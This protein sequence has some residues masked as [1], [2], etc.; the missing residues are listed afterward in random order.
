MVISRANTKKVCFSLSVALSICL[1][2]LWLQRGTVYILVTFSMLYSVGEIISFN[3]SLRR[4][5]ENRI[6]IGALL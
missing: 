6:N 4:V 3:S 5:L 1:P 2:V